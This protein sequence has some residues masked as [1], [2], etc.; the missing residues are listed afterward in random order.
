MLSA[1]G[2]KLRWPLGIT[3][4]LLFALLSIIGVAALLIAEKNVHIWLPA[5]ISNAAIRADRRSARE[6]ADVV[7]VIFAIVDHFEPVVE[8]GHDPADK[9]DAMA[10]WLARY[11]ALAGRHRDSDGRPPRHTWV[12]PL[13][14]YDPE[15]LTQLVG[16][17]RRGLGEIEVHIHHANDTSE[18][19]RARMQT[20]LRLF[21]KHG[22]NTVRGIE[23]HRFVFV[24][25]NWALDNSGCGCGVNDE[26]QIL[27]ELGCFVD[28]T[29]P[30]APNCAQTR[31]INSVYYATDDPKRPKSHDDGVDVEVGGSPSGD[32]MILQGPLRPDWANRKY[33]IFPRIDNA[34]LTNVATGRPARLDAW[35]DLGIGVVGRP[36]WVFI[37]AHTHGAHRHTREALLGKPADEMFTHLEQTYAS[38]RYR[39]HYVT[40]R[41]M[42]N[43]VKAAEAG[44]TGNPYDYR[45]FAIPPYDCVRGV[46][47]ARR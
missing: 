4:E 8:P 47:T 28:M 38:G 17:C 46:S 2:K 30:S 37:K 27:R 23:G 36:E 11:P 25:G 32:L 14:T 6:A 29:L 22:V 26:L 33:G 41:E 18:T 21:A 39:L 1:R 13:E 19:F 5:Y 15:H 40:A 31:K 20:G 44:K 34:D 10:D 9:K 42:Y 45:D 7:H 24:H 3:L 16:L 35:V 43:M 12:Y